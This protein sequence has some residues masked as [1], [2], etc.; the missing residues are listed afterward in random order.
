MKNM[1]KIEPNALKNNPID[2]IGKEWLLVSAGNREQYNTMTAS[3]GSIG[4]FFNMPVATIVI[5]PERYTF[6]FLERESHF[7]LSVLVEGHRDALA[8]LGTIS[9]RDCD[10]IT[11][12]GLTP[13]FTES[14]LPTFKE[15]RLVLECRKI[16]GQMMNQE[17]FIDQ[18][19][20]EKWYNEAKGN[21]HKIF[22]GE[23]ES[24]WIEEC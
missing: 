16:Y 14:G 10:K 18:S 20:F 8:I 2:I 23:I 19:I 6:E 13:T 1:I 21:P 15:A 4:Y 11:Q 3:W 17:S 22:M 24:C 5:R 7:T 12:T 9:G